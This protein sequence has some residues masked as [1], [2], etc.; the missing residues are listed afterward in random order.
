[1]LYTF[2]AGIRILDQA[3]YSSLSSAERAEARQAL[4]AKIQVVVDLMG[5][6]ETD[7]PAKFLAARLAAQKAG[8]YGIGAP[9]GEG[10]RYVIDPAT[11]KVICVRN[12]TL[13]KDGK[14]LIL[15]VTVA[16]KSLS[17]GFFVHQTAIN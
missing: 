4:F 10:V 8:A 9:L 14:E 1:M 16:G 7:E 12:Y 2:A 6:F 5:A 3:T 17:S 13:E 15:S 11:G